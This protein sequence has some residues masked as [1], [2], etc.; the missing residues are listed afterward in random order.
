ME[1][2]LIVFMVILIISGVSLPLYLCIWSCGHQDGD[3]TAPSPDE[4]TLETERRKRE[5]LGY[6]TTLRNTSKDKEQ[7][8][9]FV[10][11]I[12]MGPVATDPIPDYIL[13][14]INEVK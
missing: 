14:S 3:I 11:C 4:D 9:N 1:I 6:N 2:G 5:F 7:D 12:D 10:K 8:D 13:K